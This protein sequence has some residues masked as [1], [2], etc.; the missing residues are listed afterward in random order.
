MQFDV[1]EHRP[2][3]VLSALWKNLTTAEA[4]GDPEA[5]YIRKNLRILVAGGDGTVTWVLGAILELGMDPSPAIA[6]MPLGTGNDF[7]FNFGWGTKF[8]WSWVKS[9]QLYR[10]LARYKDATPRAMDVWASEFIAPDPSYW[11][12]MPH[13]LRQNKDNPN[14]SFARFWNYFSVGLDAE[15]AYDFHHLREMHPH[16]ASGRA[17]NQAWY[18]A[19]SCT[20]GWFCGAAP[21]C[22]KFKMRVKDAVGG[23]WREIVVPSSV[24][25]VVLLN[26]Q[27][28]GGGRDIWGLAHS[29][30]LAK[31][32]LTEPVYDDGLIEVLGF[33]SGWH[34]AAVMGQLNKK[35][36]AKRL[37]QCQ[38][39]EIE[40]LATEGKVKDDRGIV[41][42]QLDGEPWKQEI[43]AVVK[44]GRKKESTA[45]ESKESFK[46]RI[47]HGGQSRVLVNAADSLGT[48]QSQWVTHRALALT[49][50]NETSINGSAGQGDER[51]P[52]QH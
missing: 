41:Y 26:L 45:E 52:S 51:Q 35:V 30:T 43:P 36:H 19:F 24:R 46:V 34:T 14:T 10:T 44:K 3:N 1:T 11:K 47:S 50:S 28:Y 40:L 15:A 39:V 25:A 23:E 49:H 42:M 2:L 33:R 7:S 18:G 8:E 21:L 17:V 16:L 4:K 20:T 48:R 38:E 13:S 27:S 32:G 9:N 6:V 22:R 37:A 29:S 5:A 31:K 12:E